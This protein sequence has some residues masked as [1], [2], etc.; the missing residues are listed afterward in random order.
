MD[1]II[2]YAFFFF[3][4]GILSCESQNQENIKNIDTVLTEK[5][6]LLYQIEPQETAKYK[7]IGEIPAPE[8]FEK[9]SVSPDSYGYFIRNLALKT[10]NNFV[11]LYNGNLKY[12]QTVQ[13]AVLTTDVGN[14][15]LQQCADAV[16]RIRAEYLFQSKKY[17]EIHF[18]FLSDNK[19]RYFKDY[20]AGNYSY[21]VFRKYM[22]YIFSYANTASLKNELLKVKDLND[23][24]IGDVFI[25]SGNPYGHAVTVADIAINNKNEKVFLLAQSYMP[26]QDI[27]ILKNPED[28]QISPWYY[29][30]KAGALNTPEWT[31]YYTDLR[32]FK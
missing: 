21:P 18:N 13:F 25:Q 17:N 6:D 22:N 27:H 14:K 15:D 24:Q 8:G 5:K 1:K 9:T 30:K 11:F 20:Q 29:L 7:T 16:M 19:P 23:I 10:D 26:A 2:I 3:T 32:R 31:F 12:N 28:K 4:V